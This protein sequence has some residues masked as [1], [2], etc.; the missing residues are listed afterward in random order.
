MLKLRYLLIHL[1][2]VSFIL[3]AMGGYCAAPCAASDRLKPG[4]I[5]ILH[6]SSNF[7]GN[8]AFNLGD[9]T[10]SIYME[11]LGIEAFGDEKMTEILICNHR[12]KTYL[13]E[14]RSEWKKRAAKYQAKSKKDA[15]YKGFK[16][17]KG[18]ATKI[19]GLNCS[20]YEINAIK[21]DGTLEKQANKKQLWV[22][23]ELESGKGVA[24][25]F[26]MEI[27]RVFAQIDSIPSTG[28]V[29]MRLKADKSGKLVTMLDT[30]KVEKSK[31]ALKLKVPKGYHRVKD[32]VALLWGD[33]SSSGEMFGSP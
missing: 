28:G 15:Q 33:E 6:M 21:L 4:E 12:D 23:D 13:Q 1:L 19:C 14:P 2:L 17:T 9:S 10:T 24:K 22:C 5:W 31:K 32:E 16:V 20:F 8:V 27:L 26:A 18:K 30:Y 29:L 7:L 25:Q 3:A 11:K